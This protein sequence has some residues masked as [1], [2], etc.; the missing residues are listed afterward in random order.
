MDVKIG[1]TVEVVDILFDRVR[2]LCSSSG[3]RAGQTLRC[4]R[5]TPFHLLL[6]REDGGTVKIDRF[7]ACFVGVR[8]VAAGRRASPF[9]S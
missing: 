2:D 6:Q 1:D 7:Y 5:R 4:D 3:I 8:P 9:R